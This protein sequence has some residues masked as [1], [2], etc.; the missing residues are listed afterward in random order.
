VSDTQASPAFVESE[1][2]INIMMD[3]VERVL[4]HN[5]L[6]DY[7]REVGY[8]ML[9]YLNVICDTIHNKAVKRRFTSE[10]WYSMIQHIRNGMSVGRFHDELQKGIQNERILD[11]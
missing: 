6:K 2:M 5:D 9:D 8:D 3:A 4:S 1:K 10:Q 7:E 11:A